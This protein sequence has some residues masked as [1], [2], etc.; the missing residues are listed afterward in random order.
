MLV[1]LTALGPTSP[2]VVHQSAGASVR[3]HDK[4]ALGNPMSDTNNPTPPGEINPVALPSVLIS[5]RATLPA[6][7]AVY[8]CIN[9][10]RRIEGLKREIDIL[11]MSFGE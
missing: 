6:V 10:R 1:S 7:A 2:A 9:A 11:L 5:D 4:M 3:H 8:F